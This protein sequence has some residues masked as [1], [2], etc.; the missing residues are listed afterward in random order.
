MNNKISAYT[1]LYYDLQFYESIIKNIYNYV[2]EIIIIDGPYS[3]AIDTLKKFNLFYDEKNKP[4]IINNL[5]NKYNKIKYFYKIFDNEENKRMFGYDMCKNNIILLVDTDEFIY[6]NKSN[7]KRFINDKN[8]YVCSTD[9]YNMCDY[10]VYINNISKKNIFFKKNKITSF[11]HLD[12]TWLVGCKQN[13]IINSYITNYSSSMTYHLTLFR[14]KKNNIIKFFFYVLLYRKNNKLPY[15][16]LDNYDNN[17]LLQNF[18]NNQILNIF[19]HS[20][21]DSINIPTN[22]NVVKLLNNYPFDLHKFKNNSIDFFFKNNMKSLKNIPSF[23]RLNSKNHIN[24]YINIY[25]D[26]V[27]SINISFYN[28]KYNKKYES[29]ELSFNDIK[30]NI[31]NVNN[32]IKS[33]NYKYNIIKILVTETINN[34]SIFTLKNII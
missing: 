15:N 26:N 24:N 20:K 19:I 28:I 27:K 30:N 18:N 17:F 21:L 23:F 1:I 14:N 8:R 12:Y 22:D 13:K 11:Q 5:L 33:S 32:Y 6:L 25:F 4:Q 9:I 31:I 34:N 3:Y 7:L 16:I 29:I 10:N 2:D